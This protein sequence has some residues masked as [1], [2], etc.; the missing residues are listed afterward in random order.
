MNF[1]MW[2]GPWIL[3]LQ[4]RSIFS[5]SSEKKFRLLVDDGLNIGLAFAAGF[6]EALSSSRIGIA[7]LTSFSTPLKILIQEVV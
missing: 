2:K 3:S 1:D 5:V 4:C 6:P 7:S